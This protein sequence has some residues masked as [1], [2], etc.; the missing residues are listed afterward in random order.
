MGRLQRHLDWCKPSRPD[1]LDEPSQVVLLGAYRQQAQ[2]RNAT[3]H[4]VVVKTDNGIAS[5]L[6]H[7]IL[8]SA[9]SGFC[10]KSS[11]QVLTK[12]TDMLAKEDL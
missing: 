5:M 11:S 10:L 4:H 1:Q 7:S 6:S 9:V 2:V 12:P 8:T 3:S